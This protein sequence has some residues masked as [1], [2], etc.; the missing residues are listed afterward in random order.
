MPEKFQDSAESEQ[1]PERSAETIS[2]VSAKTRRELRILHE[3]LERGE[4][5]V[6]GEQLETIDV[7]PEQ[8]QHETPVVVVPG[9]TSTGNAY[10]EFMV[11]L[12]ENG[13]RVLSYN[14]PHG[15][16][17]TG[18]AAKWSHAEQLRKAAALI[19][20]LEEKGIEQADIVAHSE[21]AIVTALVAHLRPDL[22]RNIVLM[23]PAGMV[24]K[25]SVPGFLGRA[26]L[27]TVKYVSDSISHIADAAFR[28]IQRL[29]LTESLKSVL[30]D[31][32]QTY[33]ELESIVD[34]ELH[35]FL[36]VLQEEQGKNVAVV[37][38]EKDYLYPPRKMNRY[39]AAA[40]IPEDRRFS[41]DGSHNSHAT[42]P[43]ITASVAEQAL[44]K[45]DEKSAIDEEC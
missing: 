45:L 24:G 31:P 10:R 33:K 21:G 37:Q 7:S 15:V 42:K 12:V 8:Q 36:K 20:M 34:M 35:E 16:E 6:D 3:F 18:N 32:I 17:I 23:Q 26:S 44:L 30:G 11:P 13:R 38:G 9:V 41:V 22:I 25:G 27:D 4:L 19:A 2:D 28:K 29:M 14:A 1:Q 43:R 40:G 5:E 39:I